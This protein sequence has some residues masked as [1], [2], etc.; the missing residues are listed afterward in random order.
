MKPVW[1]VMAADGR[2]AWPEGP[3]PVPRVYTIRRIDVDAGEVDI[4][5]VLH[6]GDKTS[7][8][9]FALHAKPGD[10]GGMTGS[11]GGELP[12][13]DGTCLPGTRPR[14]QRWITCWSNCRPARTW[15]ALI[16]IVDDAE[17]QELRTKA[18]LD[19]HWLSREGRA[20]GSTPLLS[21]AVRTLDFPDDD[22]STF[23]WAGCEHTAAREI[24]AHLRKERGLQRRYSLIAVYW[25]R[26]TAGDVEECD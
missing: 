4:D 15:V 8:A 6:E 5:F 14:F 1:P 12:E 25:R 20:A 11:G 23:V 19:L 17:R 9:T 26:G 18:H 13:A 22:A 24:R 16:E 3:R 10:P 7:G 21:D 2:Q